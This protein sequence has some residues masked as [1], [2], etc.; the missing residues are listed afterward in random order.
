MFSF[1]DDL[2]EVI[3]SNASTNHVDVWHFICRDR[4]NEESDDE[5]VIS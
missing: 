2:N 1:V 3:M 5:F 4:S